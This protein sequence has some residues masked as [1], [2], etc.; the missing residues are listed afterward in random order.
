MGIEVRISDFD[1]FTFL[2]KRIKF[3]FRQ[4]INQERL[5]K[6]EKNTSLHR[7][8]ISKTDYIKVFFS[9]MHCEASLIFCKRK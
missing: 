9:G 8:I 7:G 1:S 4:P 5:L 3:R 6:S 2:V